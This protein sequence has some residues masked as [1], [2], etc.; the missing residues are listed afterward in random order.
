MSRLTKM[1]C[2]PRLVM[3][4]V[5]YVWSMF[6]KSVTFS[7]T[8]LSY[9]LAVI[10]A[11][12]YALDTL[13][14]VYNIVRVAVQLLSNVVGIACIGKS[15]CRDP[16]MYVRASDAVFATFSYNTSWSTRRATF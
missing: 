3:F 15:N 7:S 6:N 14:Q 2:H 12:R 16:V 4:L 8:S 10:V 1:L 5:E 9:V 13:Y 11:V